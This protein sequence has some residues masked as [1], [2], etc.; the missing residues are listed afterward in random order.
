[1]ISSYKMSTPPNMM[2]PGEPEYQVA[3]VSILLTNWSAEKTGRPALDK[4]RETL[5]VY[6]QQ[7]T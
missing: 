6:S 5:S 2:C 3:D 1:M 7:L 4:S